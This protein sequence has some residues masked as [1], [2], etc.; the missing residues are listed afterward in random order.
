MRWKRKSLVLL[1]LVTRSLPAQSPPMP[2]AAAPR[3]DPAPR[4]APLAVDDS[5]KAITT[6]EAWATQRA[7]LLQSWHACMGEFSPAKAPLKTEIVTTEEFP[8]FVRQ[9]VRYQIEDGITTEA[10]LLTPKPAARTFPAV[11]VFH[12]T[13][14]TNI[15]QAAGLDESKPELNQGVQLVR[16]GYVVLCPR[17]FIFEDGAY[18]AGGFARNVARMRQRHPDWTGL[19]RMSWDAVRAADFLASLPHVDRARIGAI[20]HSLGAREALYAAA[21]DERYRAVVFN[22]GGIDLHRGNWARVWYLGPQILQPDFALEH[23]QLLALIAPRAFL[24]LAGDAEDHDASRVFIEAARP[25]Y[26]LF[27]A[28]KNL[29]WFNHH[30]GHRYPPEARTVAEAFLDAQLKP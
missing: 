9:L 16:R 14:R 11:V 3:A 30:A 22:E 13:T 1:L 5:G 29:G 20:G 8:D 24:L 17:C 12:Q 19:A 25:V 21:F 27:G 28:E 6:A 15:R 2:A 23:H 18:E 4:L 26:R 7:T 10:Y